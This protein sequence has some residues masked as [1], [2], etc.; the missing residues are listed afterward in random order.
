MAIFLK[1]ILCVKTGDVGGELLRCY[2]KMV[3]KMATST[4]HVIAGP[5]LHRARSLHFGD[6]RNIFL[7]NLGEDQKSL[8]FSA[9][10]P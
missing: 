3:Q 8:T 6:F 10:G 2:W 5:D 4:N 9:R 7:P 1:S